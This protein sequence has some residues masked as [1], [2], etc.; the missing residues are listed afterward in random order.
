M[1]H[2]TEDG[3][4]EDVP[5]QVTSPIQRLNGKV[6]INPIDTLVPTCP[7]M[8]PLVLVWSIHNCVVKDEY[9]Y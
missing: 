6:G 1:F 9:P 5:S 8:S 2:A 4:L 3:G 7:Y